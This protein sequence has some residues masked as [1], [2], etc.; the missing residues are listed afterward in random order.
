MAPDVAAS[1]VV[2][3]TREM[4]I[5]AFYHLFGIDFQG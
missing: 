3:N 2:T 1:E 5:E 4:A